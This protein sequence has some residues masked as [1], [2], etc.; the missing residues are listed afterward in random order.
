[1]RL[2]LFFVW[3]AFVLVSLTPALALAQSKADIAKLKAAAD[4]AMDNLRYADALDGY[5]KA[6]AA[7]H[8]ARFLYNMGRALGALGE[9][10][11]A[12]EQLE[13]FRIDAPAD[14]K[15]R[16]PQLEQLIA[17][18]KRHVST[19]TVRCNVEGARVLL[20]DKEIGRT[21]LAEVKVNAGPAVVEVDADGYEPKKQ[22][23]ELPGGDRIEVP[24]ELVKASPTGILVVRSTPA[25]TSV[26]VDG[27]GLG[28]TPLETSLLPG[29]HA[30][31]LSREGYRDLTTR[32]VVER[33]MRREL[34]FKLEKT[35]GVLTRWWFW[36]VVGVV[37]AGAVAGTVTAFMCA[38]T[39]AC[40]RS[41]DFGSID[42]QQVRGP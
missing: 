31:L 39:T 13:R 35:P 8:D 15:S 29:S 40:E 20:R 27:K 5:Q 17:D 36:T 19:L 3:L 10:P 30:L 41:A 33:G 4:S 18:F 38:N 21:P 24:F 34:D 28:G 1:M 37:V 32:A 22:N 25:A 42:P 12:V 26:L 14:L 9:Y 23:V 11:Q 6:Y 16:V 2:R 7:S